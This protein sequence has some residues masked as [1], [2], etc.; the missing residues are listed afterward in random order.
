[1]KY[2]IIIGCGKTG[3][4]LA[5]ELA[6]SHNVVVVDKNKRAIDLLGEAF[7]GK[8]ILGDALNV[9]VLEEAGIKDAD[10]LI[11]VTGNDNFNLVVGRVARKMYKVEKV[12]LQVYEVSKKK[13][14]S[15]EGLMTI[16]RT[17]ILVEV[18]KKC[19]L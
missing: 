1:M 2:I 16:N 3:R 6:Q 5:L 13:M 17:K 11:L 4:N 19:I 15:Q 14:F 10:A 12:V 18:F 8:K 7:N 9:T